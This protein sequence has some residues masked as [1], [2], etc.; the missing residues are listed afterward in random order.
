MAQ[1][2]A[3]ALAT[4]IW[5]NIGS[6]YTMKLHYFLSAMFLAL[7][8]CSGDEQDSL[9]GLV[10]LYPTDGATNISVAARVTAE[11]AFE[12]GEKCRMS[13]SRTTLEVVDA[14]GTN[15]EGSTVYF[16]DGLRADFTPSGMFDFSKTYTVRVNSDCSAEATSEFTVAGPESE[17]L[18]VPL[19]TGFRLDDL[20]V[21]E[22]AALKDLLRGFLQDAELIA[23]SLEVGDSDIR[24]LGGEGKPVSD[25]DDPFLRTYLHNA[26]LFP[27]V[28]VYKPPYFQVEGRLVIP[29]SELD[30]ITLERFEL[31]GKFVQGL[32][33][34]EIIESSIRASSPCDQI[35]AVQDQDLQFVCGNRS[36]ICDENGILNLIGTFQGTPNDLMGYQTITVQTQESS[37]GAADGIALAAQSMTENVPV[38]STFEIGLTKAVNTAK[39]GAVLV[40]LTADGDT[41]LDPVP[42]TVS[43][44]GLS[45][46]FTPATPLATGTTY[47]LLVVAHRAFETKFSTP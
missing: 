21:S 23:Q 20:T 3:G 25:A 33:G 15:V 35:C 38:D 42:A 24:M 39:T 10:T 7:V 12:D 13:P 26:F 2:L 28:G 34:I 1:K 41:A 22:P 11:I 18:E 14:D 47:T 4:S 45:A 40:Q 43:E 19:N 32:G 8:A 9:E 29:A 46:T 27:M 5:V 30:D 6:E 36:T 37:A 31:S 44:D 17:T 16:I